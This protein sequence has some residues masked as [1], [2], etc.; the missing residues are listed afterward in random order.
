MPHSYENKKKNCDA[1][2]GYV[3]VMIHFYELAS[4]EDQLSKPVP[5]AKHHLSSNG[6]KKQNVAGTSQARRR[7]VAG[8]SHQY[9]QSYRDDTVAAQV[10]GNPG[11]GERLG[12]R[13]HTLHAVIQICT[14]QVMLTCTINLG[15]CK[16][17]AQSQL[18]NTCGDHIVS[19][20]MIQGQ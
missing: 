8:T 9:N 18:C 17:V 6:N 10:G 14:Q 7:H 3:T 20:P 1:N 13:W 11:A 12:R 19:V 16:T 5:G 4:T 15:M 2:T